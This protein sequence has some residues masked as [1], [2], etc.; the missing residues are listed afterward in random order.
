[1]PHIETY[2][3]STDDLD[4]VLADPAI[5]LETSIMTDND[6]MALISGVQ[7]AVVT[8]VN[9]TPFHCP[10]GLNPVVRAVHPQIGKLQ[11]VDILE[12]TTFNYYEGIRY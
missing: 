1:M 3:V 10:V 7:L 5:K 11:S 4:L 2:E 6:L 8:D 12:G 9:F